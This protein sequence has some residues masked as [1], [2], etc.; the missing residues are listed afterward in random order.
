MLFGILERKSGLGGMRTGDGDEQ[1]VDDFFQFASGNVTSH[2]FDHFLADG[3]DLG[4]EMVD[5]STESDSHV[6]CVC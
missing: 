4:G 6:T 2:D 5:L 3:F 1:F